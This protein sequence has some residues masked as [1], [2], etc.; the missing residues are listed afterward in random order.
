MQHFDGRSIF[1]F[2]SDFAW[3]VHMSRGARRRERFALMCHVNENVHIILENGNASTCV[4]QSCSW[5]PAFTRH[6]F[7]ILV[8]RVLPNQEDTRHGRQDAS[9][10]NKELALK[11]GV[12]QGGGVETRDKRVTAVFV[13]VHTSVLSRVFHIIDAFFHRRDAVDERD[14]CLCVRCCHRGQVT[15]FRGR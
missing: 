12:V 7:F 10:S 14:W 1:H 8:E 4:A 5:Q 3:C 11:E 6:A 13:S 2:S 15:Y 9:L